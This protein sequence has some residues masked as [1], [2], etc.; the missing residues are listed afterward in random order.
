[1]DLGR[2]DAD[3]MEDDQNSQRV[4][5][6]FVHHNEWPTERMHRIIRG[7]VNQLLGAGNN[8]SRID[9]KLSAIA[10]PNDACTLLRVTFPA[11]DSPRALSKRITNFRSKPQENLD[12]DQTVAGQRPLERHEL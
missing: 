2:Y 5:P 9:S 1:M 12:I 4:E 11:A 6:R 7:G 3:E 10:Y 8:V